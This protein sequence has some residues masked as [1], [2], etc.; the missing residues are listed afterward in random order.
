MS[1][2]TTMNHDKDEDV[3]TTT[4]TTVM[5]TTTTKW[6]S[7]LRQKFPVPFLVIALGSLVFDFA[8]E[9]R[10]F[11]LLFVLVFGT[12]VLAYLSVSSQTWQEA[13][14]KKDDDYE[15]S[16][17]LSPLSAPVKEGN[18]T[19]LLLLQQ[20]QRG[21]K[22]RPRMLWPSWAIDGLP[23]AWV[24]I[25]W[26]TY[27]R[28]FFDIANEVQMTTENLHVMPEVSAFAVQNF[29]TVS[30]GLAMFFFPNLELSSQMPRVTWALFLANACLVFLPH[31][32]ACSYV[33][34]S[35]VF[36]TKVFL[37]VITYN[38]AVA[39]DR[40]RQSKKNLRK[41]R[42]KTT[43]VAVSLAQK[44]DDD[45]WGDYY[46]S[47]E[48]Q[49][50]TNEYIQRLLVIVMQCMW[51]LF[52][53]R[54]FLVAWVP[55]PLI[56]GFQ[57][58]VLN[59]SILMEKRRAQKEEAAANNLKKLQTRPIPPPP[60]PK[61]PE[62][63]IQLLYPKELQELQQQY[64]INTGPPVLAP[65]VT[66]VVAASPTFP[67]LKTSPAPPT[68]TPAPPPNPFR[69]TENTTTTA[70]QPTATTTVPIIRNVVRKKKTATATTSSSSQSKKKAPNKTW[71]E[72]QTNKSTPIDNPK[73]QP[74]SAAAEGEDYA[75]IV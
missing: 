71:S 72:T 74:H 58:L 34:P 21:R 66:P 32:D 62:E 1:G 49:V 47:S 33:M 46:S 61:N 40:L 10:K 54:V 64:R 56:F 27:G 16:L 2:K 70:K 69:K 38:F 18:D 30:V 5:A 52:V 57:Y 14:Q 7:S 73:E 63:P 53:P 51:I 25:W 6:C 23:A 15:N 31:V 28:L 13:Q 44:N 26:M 19:E 12:G 43:R 60:P 8:L 48:I 50:E 45:D 20:Q 35:Q 36:W 17:Y 75:N 67:I 9:E 11:S 55:I 41:Q 24:W 22:H 42:L 65:S 4:T 39:I 29:F 37:F 68:T 59:T 3:S